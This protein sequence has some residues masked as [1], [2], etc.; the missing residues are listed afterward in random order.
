MNANKKVRAAAVQIGPGARSRS[1]THREGVR[2]RSTRPRPRAPSWSS[3]PRPFVPYYPY[4]SFVQA[5]GQHGQGAPA[6]VRRSRGR[7]RPDHGRGGRRRPRGRRRR[8][9]RRERARPRHRSTTRSWCSTPT[10]ALV[11]KRRKI[12]PTFHERMVWG[13]GDGSRSACGRHRR[14]PRRRAGL[15]G[16][17]QP[18]RPLRPDGGARRDPRARSFPARWSARSSPSRSR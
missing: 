16:A 6:P 9:A 18:A 8:R 15:L 3:S 13:Q 12:T 14:R 10:A 4:F 11:L 7:A 17:L 1:G 2:T 5:A